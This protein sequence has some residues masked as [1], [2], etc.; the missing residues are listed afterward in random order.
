MNLEFES[1]EGYLLSAQ[2]KTALFLI[3]IYLQDVFWFFIS[4]VCFTPSDSMYIIYDLHWLPVFELIFISILFSLFCI[5]IFRLPVALPKVMVPEWMVLCIIVLTII[6]NVLLFVFVERSARYVSGGMAGINGVVYTLSSAFSFSAMI[7]F[8]RHKQ[9]GRPIPIKLLI[10]F[11]LSSS[12]IIDGIAHALTIGVFIFLIVGF[13]LRKISNLFALLFFV[14]LLLFVGVNSK[15]SVGLPGYVDAEFLIRWSV[16]RFSIQS[17]QAYTFLSGNSIINNQYEYFDIIMKSID[18]RI[19][20][21]FNGETNFSNPKSLSAAILYDMKGEFASGS[22]PGLLYGSILQGYFAFFIP[23]LLYFF[24]YIQF[25]KGSSAP[26][27][28]LEL[29]ALSFLFKGLHSNFSEYLVLISP[30]LLY[31]SFFIMGCLITAKRYE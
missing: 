27:G 6:L 10:L 15:F 14:I 24:L 8:I 16:A 13:E 2:K 5:A 29:V 18:N 11:L 25:F 4:R 31:A 9:I 30:T 26:L 7:L 21:I 17:E 19:N 12:L 20:F 22:S 1:R 28:I 23:P 3:F